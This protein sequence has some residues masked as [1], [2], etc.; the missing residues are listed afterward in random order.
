MTQ[1]PAQRPVARPETD[2]APPL[3]ISRR[4][5]PALSGAVAGMC[6]YHEAGRRLVGKVETAALI[7]P[8]VISFGGPF[9]IALGRRPRSDE[10][11]GSFTSGLFAGHV[12]IDSG[13]DAAC[14]QIDFTPLGAYRFFGLPM[15]EISER[16]VKLDDLADRELAVLQRRLEDTSDWNVRLDLAEAFIAERLRR[17][18]PISR[19]VASAYHELASSNGNVRIS[20]I[21]DRLDW[22]RKHLS[23]RFREEIGLPPKPL[24]RMLRFNRLLALAAQSARPDWAGLAAD[25]GYA[26]QAHLSREFADLAGTSPVRWQ[27]AA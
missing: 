15:R 23:Q 10:D 9:Q 12:V 21:A 2:H 11:Y 27:A 1:E 26:D 16:M 14:I 7:V 24:A 25:C 17:G 3:F 8:L 6:G 4:P 13:G 18:P 19:G 20:A 5:N 22:S